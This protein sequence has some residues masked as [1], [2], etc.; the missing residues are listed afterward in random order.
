MTT[1]EDLLTPALFILEQFQ[2]R[3]D[4]SDHC[5]CLYALSDPV[6]FQKALKQDYF[7]KQ[8]LFQYE[9]WDGKSGDVYG[10]RGAEVDPALG[11]G[12]QGTI[13]STN[14]A[15]YGPVF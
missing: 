6:I 3:M 11:Q 12:G 7:L 15:Y 1:I 14:D 9:N 8:K 4:V 13:R 10:L 2:I 5:S